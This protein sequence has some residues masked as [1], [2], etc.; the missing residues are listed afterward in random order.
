[1]LCAYLSVPASLVCTK[2]NTPEGTRAIA[3]FQAVSIRYHNNNARVQ[4]RVPVWFK[5]AVLV[6]EGGA[7]S[8]I[9]SVFI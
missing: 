9:I 1:M 3:F 6:I 8:D 5:C 2:I 7:C 4:S